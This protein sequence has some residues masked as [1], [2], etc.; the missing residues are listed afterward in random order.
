MRWGRTGEREKTAV[1]SVF[2]PCGW[3]FSA[4]HDRGGTRR[5]PPR[6]RN[7]PPR[8]ISTAMAAA[9]TCAVQ[10]DKPVVASPLRI[11]TLRAIRVFPCRARVEPKQ[12][13]ERDG[14][15]SQD[16]RQAASVCAKDRSV[17]THESGGCDSGG[18]FAGE[19]GRIPGAVRS[20]AATARKRD[21]AP[22][23]GAR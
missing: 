4:K 20:R 23:L 9:A 1:L 13:N 22:N 16:G 10:L 15:G 18:R 3:E 7:C 8:R 6:E 14:A 5:T 17:G 2:P 19:E 21:A 12:R 11:C